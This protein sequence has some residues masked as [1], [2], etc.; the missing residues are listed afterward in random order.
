MSDTDTTGTDAV[1]DAGLHPDQADNT[2]TGAQRT[3]V[4]AAESHAD[5]R[6]DTPPSD[7]PSTEQD[8]AEG[9]TAAAETDAT[10]TELARLDREHQ[11]ATARLTQDI[12]TA[13][14]ELA[15]LDREL[16]ALQTELER[17]EVAH[18]TGVPEGLLIGCS[19]RAEMEQHAALLKQWRADNPVARIPPG[20]LK[21]GANFAEPVIYDPRQEAVIAVRETF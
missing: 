1:P 5:E 15:E 12:A 7:S 3:T 20:R 8:T 10:A 13:Q 9:D 16:A 17:V 21:S 18:A 6:T 2:D 4:T 11:W 19:T 14:S